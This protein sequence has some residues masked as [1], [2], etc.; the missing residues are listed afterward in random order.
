[1]LAWV[2]DGLFSRS[3]VGCMHR[4]GRHGGILHNPVSL[5]FKCTNILRR[6]TSFSINTSDVQFVNEVQVS[7]RSR[8]GTTLRVAAFSFIA[9]LS[10]FPPLSPPAFL[11][12]SPWGTLFPL[13]LSAILSFSLFVSF[14][15]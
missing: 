14:H 7:L 3:C 9:L 1:M 13:S 12:F 5:N 10:L 6:L 8:P 4:M 15:H 2:L 11:G